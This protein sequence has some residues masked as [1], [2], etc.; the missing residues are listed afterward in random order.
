MKYIKYYENIDFEDWEDEEFN[1]KDY[2]SDKHGE[3][4]YKLEGNPVPYVYHLES[5]KN[6]CERFIDKFDFTNEE[7]NIIITSAWC[8]DLLE[9][10][11]VT[12][13]ELSD[14]FGKDVARVVFNLSGFG[15]NRKER[16]QNAY[17]KI[18][19]DRISTF[20][21]LCDRISNTEN[22]F[23]FPRKMEMYKKEF[24][25]FESNLRIKGELD[26]IWNYLYF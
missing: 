3:Q 15:E 7:K 25:N 17:D 26:L 11:N 1:I 6:I 9:D 23:N 22:S 20:V 24:P 10:T 18:R 19:G 12:Y 21:K 13:K 8:H 4:K 16:N 14:K 5:V 2:V